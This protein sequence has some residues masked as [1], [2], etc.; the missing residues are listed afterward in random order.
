M[1]NVIL[2]EKET[3][4]SVYLNEI[5]EDKFYGC[6]T[7]DDTKTKKEKNFVFLDDSRHYILA[8]IKEVL[9]DAERRTGGELTFK[10][11][12]NHCS[13]RQRQGRWNYEFFEFDTQDEL[14]EWLVEGI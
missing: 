8:T 6:I 13:N 12:F 1:R 3:V 11:L 10:G 7:W 5:S 9:F 4:D 2:K 14:I